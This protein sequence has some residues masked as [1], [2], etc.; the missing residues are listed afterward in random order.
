LVG[1]AILA[2]GIA[3]LSKHPASVFAGGN[4]PLESL[5]ASAF[6]LRSFGMKLL[7]RNAI[8]RQ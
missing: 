4:Q 6:E 3:F 2:P 7:G 1:I 8:L 5:D